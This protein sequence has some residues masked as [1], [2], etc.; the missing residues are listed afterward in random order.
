[1]DAREKVLAVISIIVILGALI[2]GSMSVLADID[3]CSTQFP[4]VKLS[5]CFFSS[6]FRV[7]DN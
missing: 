6:K 2:I 3:A 5:T 7:T 1:M 4:E